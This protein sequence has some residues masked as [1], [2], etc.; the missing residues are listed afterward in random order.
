ME[1][2]KNIKMLTIYDMFYYY[3]Y[4]KICFIMRNMCLEY[5]KLV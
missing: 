3:N 1:F 5:T 2:R 4:T